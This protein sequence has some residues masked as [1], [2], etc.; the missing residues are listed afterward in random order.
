MSAT[1]KNELNNVVHFN[2]ALNH[3]LNPYK[4]NFQ[5]VKSYKIIDSLK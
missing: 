1:D 5:S 4:F 3:L 2:Y